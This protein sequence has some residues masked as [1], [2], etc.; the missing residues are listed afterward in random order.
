M[1][2]V[3]LVCHVECF[4]CGYVLPVSHVFWLLDQRLENWDS[5]INVAKCEDYV[6]LK[7]GIGV[8]T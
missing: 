4:I 3:T 5:P 1:V 7:S 2:F 6:I 8:E